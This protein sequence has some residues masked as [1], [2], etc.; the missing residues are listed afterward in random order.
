M[1]ISSGTLVKSGWCSYG[2]WARRGCSPLL[3]SSRLRVVDRP[4]YEVPATNTLKGG[5]APGREP[6]LSAKK[7]RE[8]SLGS[9]G[10][11]ARE[12]AVTWW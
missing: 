7:R 8:V 6:I 10:E 5:M 11:E 12:E 3:R 1:V 4:A 2:A 9:G